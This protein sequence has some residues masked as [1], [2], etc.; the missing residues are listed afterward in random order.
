MTL[1]TTHQGIF[2]L[3]DM[4]KP[5]IKRPGISGTAWSADIPWLSTHDILY[6]DLPCCAQGIA[7][8]MAVKKITNAIGNYNARWPTFG[9]RAGWG[10]TPG[11]QS[12]REGKV[13]SMS[14]LRPFPCPGLPPMLDKNCQLQFVYVTSDLPQILPTISPHARK[15]PL[16]L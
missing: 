12:S 7:S 16:V 11:W 8:D 3:H 2:A 5:T 4:Q 10:Q 6:L 15:R 1:G 9:W 13:A 14:I